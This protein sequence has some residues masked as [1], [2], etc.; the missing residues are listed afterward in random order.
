MD[1]V[2][3]TIT[4]RVDK[5]AAVYEFALVDTLPVI[6]YPIASKF[7]IWIT[8]IKLSPKVKYGFYILIYMFYE[9]IHG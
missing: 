9:I 8:Y 2:W 6:Y 3:R 7:H 5:M 1:F 4:I